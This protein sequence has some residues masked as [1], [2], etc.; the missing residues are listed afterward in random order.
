MPVRAPIGAP[1]REVL[2]A[3]R[4]AVDDVPFVPGQPG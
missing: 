3:R 1:A 2:A 4:A